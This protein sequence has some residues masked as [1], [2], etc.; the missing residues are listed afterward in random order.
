[1]STRG[2]LAALRASRLAD[3]SVQVLLC[4]GISRPLAERLKFGGVTVFSH[5]KGDAEQVLHAFLDGTLP[6][7]S[8]TVSAPANAHI[9]GVSE[10][11]QMIW[12]KPE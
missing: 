12:E 11:L 4:A 9:L 8:A 1:M 6:A 7:G 10:N 5:L 3:L 2:S